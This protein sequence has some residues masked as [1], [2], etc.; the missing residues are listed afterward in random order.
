MLLAIKG[1]NTKHYTCYTHV[2]DTTAECDEHLSVSEYLKVI[3]TTAVML[4]YIH[5]AKCIQ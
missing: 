4:K 5:A 1:F 2:M 3:S